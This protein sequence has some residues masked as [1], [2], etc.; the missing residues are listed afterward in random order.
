MTK[1]LSFEKLDMY[2]AKALN[3]TISHIEINTN[4]NNDIKIIPIK[5]K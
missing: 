3:T 2:N 5:N 1:V 4:L